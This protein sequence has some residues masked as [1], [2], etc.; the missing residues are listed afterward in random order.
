MVTIGML[1]PRV[2]EQYSTPW[3]PGRERT[4]ARLISTLRMTRR[5]L[6]DA[7]ALWP[8]ARK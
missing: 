6:P 8:A 1:P 3:T 5:L 2:R 7:I 4:L